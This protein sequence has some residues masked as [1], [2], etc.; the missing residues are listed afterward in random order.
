MVDKVNVAYHVSSMKQKGATSKLFKKLAISS[1]GTHSLKGN[2]H[3]RANLCERKKYI[4]IR[5]SDEKGVLMMT[6]N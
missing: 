3:D 4:K 1:Q 6:Y 5:K 2:M